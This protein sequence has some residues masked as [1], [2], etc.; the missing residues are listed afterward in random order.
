MGESRPLF[1]R[2]VSVVNSE[3]WCGGE[4]DFSE[5]EAGLALG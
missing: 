1:R 4:V 3:V 5:E 2:I